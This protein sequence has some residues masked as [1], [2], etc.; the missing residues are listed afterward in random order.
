ML[1][2][3]KNRIWPSDICSICKNLLR[4]P[5]GDANGNNPSITSTSASASQMELLS[6]GIQC[7][8]LGGRAARATVAES[9]EELAT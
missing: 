8:F 7:L 9:L 1:I 2:K 5:P 6:K 4:H 3:A